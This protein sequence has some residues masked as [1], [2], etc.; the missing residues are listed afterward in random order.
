MRI[1][2]PAAPTG[3]YAYYTRTDFSEHTSQISGEYADVVVNLG[4]DGQFVFSREYSYRPIWLYGGGGKELEQKIQS[5]S[6]KF[7]SST[8]ERKGL[9][10]PIVTYK[11]LLNMP[12]KGKIIRLFG[13]YKNKRFNVINFRS[14]IDIAAE[15]GEPVRAVFSGK[16]VYASWFKGYGN[17]IIIDHGRNFHTV[18]AHVE[19]IFKA[20][21]DT[22]ETGEVIA[23]VGDT[24]SITGP[25][26]HFEVRHHG[27]PLNL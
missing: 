7:D 26:L 15:M 12:V 4:T 25:Q 22:V 18:Y 20:K 6:R 24:G 9:N 1:T 21:G 27:K 14:G 11:G 2:T 5:L 16:I 13:P 23:T 3:F 10:K 19:D 17:M 8:E